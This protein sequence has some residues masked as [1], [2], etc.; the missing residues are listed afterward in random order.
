MIDTN[1]RN[2][3][4]TVEEL[5][6]AIGPR[7]RKKRVIMCHGTFDIVHPGHIRHLMYAK[8][9]ADVLVTS[10]TSDKHIQKA[11]FRPYVP[12]ELRAMNLAVLDFVDYV[13]ID[14]EPKPLRNLGE[15]Q[16]D[17][18][19]KG[20]EYV[21]GGVI[22]PRTQ[23][24]LDVLEK[25]GGEFLY[26]PGDIVYSSSAI[27]ESTP[28]DLSVEKLMLLLKGEGLT[29]DDLRGAVDKLEGIKAHVIGDTI[30]D[31][32]T[33]TTLIG[34][35]TKTP[36]FSVRHDR[37]LDYVGGAGVVAK[38][39]RAAG[40]EVT[41]TTVLGDDAFKDFV[42]KDLEAAGIKVNAIID[43]TRPT[44]N[45]NAFIADNYRLLKVD[46]V[47]NRS[48]SD[49]ILHQVEDHIRKTP[50]QTTL[51][52]DFRHGMF[53]R[54]TIPS[55]S[56]ALPQDAYRVADS[57][58]ASRWGNILDF[59]GFDLITPNEREVRF[60]LGDQDSVVRP[61]GLELY[62]QAKCK[63]L[64]LKMGPRGVIT[65]RGEPKADEDARAFFVVDTFA[66]N[67][68]DAVGAGDALLAY[69]TLSMVATGDTVTASILGSIAA[70]VECEHDGNV[71]VE[72]RD[73]LQRIAAVERHANLT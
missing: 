65:Y 61:L 60:A 20:Y 33:Y 52:C 21:K 11:N 26:T 13:V 2:K 45:K 19:A 34:G 43:P 49:R 54:H 7:P 12:E 37:Q 48:I 35:N 46:K 36:T 28:P 17:Y 57:Q 47:D 9:K 38:H 4:K 24:E 3:I 6:K 32:Y 15:I 73:V 51:F 27:I 53:N 59:V 71:P 58:V 69:A 63:T 18:F 5:K 31:S 66:E 70:A 1:Y 55:L 68:V 39:L 44:T 64:I 56:A 40:A 10:L 23:E 42:L 25:F 41:F 8:S 14:S 72:P 30:V 22:D 29:F 16:P 62:R 67:I 50:T